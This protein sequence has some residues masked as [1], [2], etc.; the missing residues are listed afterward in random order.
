MTRC[1]SAQAKCILTYCEVF[2]TCNPSIKAN[3]FFATVL[4][5]T[6]L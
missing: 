5:A 1:E 2:S 3:L 4:C 6:A